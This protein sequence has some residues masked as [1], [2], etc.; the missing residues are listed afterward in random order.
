MFPWGSRPKEYH[1]GRELYII[2]LLQTDPLPE[3]VELLDE[4]KLPKI[5]SK[6]YLLGV[7]ILNKGKLAVLPGV[8]QQSVTP[9]SNPPPLSQTPPLNVAMFNNPPPVSQMPPKMP[10]ANIPP[11]VP[12]LPPIAPAALAAEVASL[13]PEQLQELLRTLTSTQIQMP[14]LP[15]PGPPVIPPS[16]PNLNRTPSQHMPTPPMGATPP[17]GQH[18]PMPPSAQAWMPPPLPHPYPNF[19]PPNIPFQPPLHGMNPAAPQPRPPFDRP[20]YDRQEYGRPANYD[21]QS[22]DRDFQPGP[23]YRGER[24]WRGNAGH[25]G[26]HPRGGPR[27]RG[28][29]RER[30]GDGHD[31][32]RRSSDAGWP[33]RQRNEGQGGPSW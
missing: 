16:L 33:R 26:G 20:D 1:P 19:P 18:P 30:S 8:P 7:W 11:S 22:Y 28:R 3:F 27:G 24:G 12:G 25:R 6:D 32:D 14:S 31:F 17:M 4:L 5:R 15:Q 29:D 10:P 13:T 23:H 9:A 21:R 2:P